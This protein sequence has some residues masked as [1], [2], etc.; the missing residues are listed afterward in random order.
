MGCRVLVQVNIGG[1]KRVS[2]YG[3]AALL[4]PTPGTLVVRRG[5]RARNPALPKR[6]S[7]F[8][9]A[10]CVSPPRLPDSVRL[11]ITNPASLLASLVLIQRREL[12]INARPRLY[13]Y[14]L[15]T[16]AGQTIPYPNNTFLMNCLRGRSTIC[17]A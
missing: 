17:G 14:R 13:Q 10:R 9:L 5:F 4:E 16:D 8:G 2:R 12:P 7:G 15:W 3:S 1:V 11:P 6:P